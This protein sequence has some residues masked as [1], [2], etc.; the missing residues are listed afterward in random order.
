MNNSTK[1]VLIGLPCARL[2]RS[3]GRA[4]HYIASTYID[5]LIAAGATPLLIPATDNEEVLLSAYRAVDGLLLTGGVDINPQY[6]NEDINGSVD[7]DDLR[8]V[9][10]LKITRWALE[11]DFPV[12]GICRGQQL[13]NVAAGGS[14]YQDIASDLPETLQDH[15][16]SAHR[17]QRDFLAHSVRLL[18]DSKLAEIMGTTELEVNTLHHQSVKQPGQGLRVVGV[19]SDGVAEALESPAHRYVVSVQWH[20]EELWPEQAAAKN[21]FTRFVAEVRSR[22]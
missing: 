7:I 1:S 4:L 22:A 8:D 3:K 6:Y 14:L 11:E 16:E 15:Q 9:A 10:E 13:L 12:F 2:S 20:P 21:L 19:G 17:Q 18:P 5:A